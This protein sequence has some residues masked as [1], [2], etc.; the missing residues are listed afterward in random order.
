M[1]EILYGKVEIKPTLAFA[2]GTSLVLPAPTTLDLVN[3]E[4]TANNVYP[5]PA[6][7]AGQVEWAYR[8]KAIDTRGQSFE[9]MVGVP[10]ST[11]TVE[12]TT[13]PRYFETKPPLFGK[14]E[15]GDPGEAAKI[16][17]GTTTSGTTPSVTNSGTNQNAILDFVLPKG[18]KG[19]RGDGVPAGG[20]AL[21]YLRKD[22]AGANTE[23][24]NLDKASVGL[25]NVDNTSD[26]E[27]PVSTAT[28]E[29]LN[30]L[31]AGEDLRVSGLVADALSKTSEEL[32]KKFVG[33][34]T[35]VVNVADYGAVGDGITDD[36][37]AIS[38]ARQA[39]KDSGGGVLWF[40]TGT[41]LM[42]G[43]AE[44]LSDS[45]YEYNYSVF[46]KPPSGSRSSYACFAA[47]S[48]G[49]LGYGSGVRNFTARR[50]TFK[51]DFNPASYGDIC[52]FAL[53]HAEN[54][55][56]EDLVFYE[57]IGNGHAFDLNG[58]KDIT[59]IRPKFIGMRPGGGNYNRAEAIQLDMSRNGTL[60]VADTAGSY[61]GLG[62]ENITVIDAE[63]LPL[64][65]SYGEFP[66]PNLI[67]S[68]ARREGV[69]HK[70]ITVDGALI[71][72]PMEDTAASDAGVLYHSMGVDGLKLR[73]IK[74]K[75]N[76]GNNF[77][78][79]GVYVKNT[80]EAASVDPNGA[81]GAT[82]TIS[83][84]YVRNVDIEF[85]TVDLVTT[86]G[87]SYQV[88]VY[89]QGIASS[90][91]E[92]VKISSR[93]TY[94]GDS[95]DF[96]YTRMER[97]NGGEW[98]SSDTSGGGTIF[99]PLNCDAVKSNA[100]SYRNPGSFAEYINNVRGY[101]C[102]GFFVTGAKTTAISV[103]SGSDYVNMGMVAK[104]PQ[105]N[106]TNS[107]LV[108][109]INGTDGA[110]VQGVKASTTPDVGSERGMQ[111]YGA[112]NNFV[113]ANNVFAGYTTKVV[114]SSTGSNKLVDRNI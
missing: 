25:P 23:W 107:R 11:G 110:I 18:D 13:L 83:P 29:A 9:W 49:A 109:S 5:T 77:R 58:C 86:A 40:N 87:K 14:G 98:Y 106:S 73:R 4:A 92:K 27:K 21:Q 8:V 41:Y 112:S 94:L 68:H 70:N 90:F 33:V 12:F 75:S 67:G 48:K 20:T 22:S 30:G 45:I 37:S 84:L 36:T 56:F 26:A 3:G 102:T 52:G 17:I 91:A 104:E 16:T 95:A 50:G 105:G 76:T 35:L 66:C 96:I 93:A 78:L 111:I 108:L 2:R 28:Q 61:D 1:P 79:V 65:T 85:D 53:H 44:T 60:S 59:F 71:V 103:F 101:S 81:G 31:V 62:C 6:P 54:C 69:I 7:V 55:V 88:M 74:V 72:N 97:V 89:V 47:L 82:V 64:S 63:S 38:A 114:D 99:S 80:G 113:I 32:L 100:N 15:K 19:D 42:S 39:L 43:Y 10:D 34:G 51:G 46:V 24:A 57:A